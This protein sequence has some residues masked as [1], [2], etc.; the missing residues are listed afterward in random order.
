MSLPVD[1]FRAAMSAHGLVPAESII[2]DGRIHRCD[3]DAPNGRGDGAYLLHLDG[4]PA[5]GFQSWQNGAGWQDWCSRD[6]ASLTAQERQQLREAA[7]R[8]GKERE[9]ET[10]QRQSEAAEYAREIWQA[11]RAAPADQEYLTRK[12]VRAHGLRVYRGELRS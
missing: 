5:G 10:R 6:T 4:I 7:A 11:A 2:A 3:V 1:D 9:A 12:G 8:A